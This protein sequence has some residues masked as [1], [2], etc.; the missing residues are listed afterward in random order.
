MTCSPVL[1]LVEVVPPFAAS[2]LNLHVAVH[3]RAHVAQVHPQLWR[4]GVNGA[5]DLVAALADHLG[6][7]HEVPTATRQ[8]RVAVLVEH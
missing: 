5:L 1:C 7:V 3:V 4:H 8:I 2:K 6:V